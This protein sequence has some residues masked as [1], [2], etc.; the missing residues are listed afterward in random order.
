MER[1][2]LTC[3]TERRSMALIIPRLQQSRRAERH[4]TSRDQGSI[5]QRGYSSGPSG[6]EN[7]KAPTIQKERVSLF[8]SRELLLVAHL[9]RSTSIRHMG[10]RRV[11]NRRAQ[12]WMHRPCPALLRARRSQLP[13]IS[14]FAGAAF[15]NGCVLT[16][17]RLSTGLKLRRGLPRPKQTLCKEYLTAFPCLLRLELRLRLIQ[18]SRPSL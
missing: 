10:N 13:G 16:R 2:G 1:V 4:N 17:A 9:P 6:S 8:I 3:C 18:A 5:L 15:C 14:R 7:E 12:A 11:T